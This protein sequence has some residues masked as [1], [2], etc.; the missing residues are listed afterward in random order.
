MKHRDQLLHVIPAHNRV[1]RVIRAS[2]TIRTIRAA[3]ESGFRR[4]IK[5][6]R[7]IVRN[8]NIVGQSNSQFVAGTD[9]PKTVSPQDLIFSG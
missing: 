9:M 5:G 2:I 4:G 6:F 1:R 7:A 8:S 3:A